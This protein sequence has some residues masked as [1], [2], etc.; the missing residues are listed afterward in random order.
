MSLS[1]AILGLLSDHP[2]TGYDLKLVFD[3]E[4]NSFWPA[5]LSQIYRE[6]SALETKGLLKSKLHAQET[7]PDRRVYVLTDDGKRKFAEWMGLFPQSL[8]SPFRD[9]FSLRLYFGSHLPRE[10]LQ[11]QLRRFIREKQAEIAALGVLEKTFADR[12]SSRREAADHVAFNRMILRRANIMAE[13]LILWAED[14]LDELDRQ[15]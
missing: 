10:E 14:C 15:P 11:F 4:M 3:K 9:E 12:N 8:V 6:L 1:Y 5:Q 7:R 13:A 2:M